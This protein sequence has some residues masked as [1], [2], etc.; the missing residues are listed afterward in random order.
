[1]MMITGV[2]QASSE[3]PNGMPFDSDEPEDPPES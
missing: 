1:M 2:M 3:D